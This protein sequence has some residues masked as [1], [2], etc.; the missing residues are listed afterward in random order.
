LNLYERERTSM[1]SKY[2]D[3]E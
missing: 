1:I 2:L 3:N